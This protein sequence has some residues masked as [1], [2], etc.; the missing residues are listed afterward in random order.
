M[1]LM[2]TPVMNLFQFTPPRGRRL[3]HRFSSLT[4]ENYFNSRLR[5]GG[6]VDLDEN[7]EEGD[8]ISIHASA[9]EATAG[10]LEQITEETIS[11]HASAREATVRTVAR[12]SSEKNFNS[13]LRE[14]GDTAMI[15]REC[16]RS[17]FNSRLREGG[18]SKR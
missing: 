10:D 17:Y 9:R 12:N 11:I 3:W 13:R 1:I 5:E 8:E 4:Q 6:D 15:A 18:D 16:P 7:E 14:G 2:I